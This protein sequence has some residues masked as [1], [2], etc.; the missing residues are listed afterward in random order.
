MTRCR[1]LPKVP[2]S[3]PLPLVLLTLANLLVSILCM[4]LPTLRTWLRCGSPL[5]T[6]S[7]LLRLPRVTLLTWVH[8]LLAHLGKSRNLPALPVVTPPSLL[9]VL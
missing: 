2:F 6:E 8:S 3:L 5:V 7:V 1:S 9:R 4:R